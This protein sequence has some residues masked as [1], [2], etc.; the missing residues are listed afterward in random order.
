MFN[1]PAQCAGWLQYGVGRAQRLHRNDA[2]LTYLFD[3]KIHA[4][5]WNLSFP[6]K[7]KL[8]CVAACRQP[9]AAAG[10]NA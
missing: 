1:E 9:V 8:L 5:L 3:L 7:R 2:T 6:E 10:L 4:L